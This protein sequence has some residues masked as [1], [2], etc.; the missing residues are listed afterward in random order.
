MDF[1][2]LHKERKNQDQDT[3]TWSKINTGTKGQS[4]MNMKKVD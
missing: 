3:F 2:R 4:H 1:K